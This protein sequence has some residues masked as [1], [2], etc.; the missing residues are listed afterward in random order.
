MTTITLASTDPA[1][2]KIDALVLGISPGR[3]KSVTIE[4]AAVP[5]KANA[6]RRLETALTALGATGRSGELVKVPGTGIVAAPVILAVGLGAPETAGAAV[7]DRLRR[8]AGEASRALIGTRR[9]GIALPIAEPGDATTIIEGALMGGYTFEAFRGVGTRERRLETRTFTVLVPDSKAAEWKQAAAAG[10]T[11]GNA[12]R[13]ARDLVNTPASHLAPENLAEAALVAADDLPLDVTVFDEND[14]LEGG[15]GGILSVGKGS[16]N[17]PRLIQLTYRHPSAKR[18]LALVGKGITFDSGGLSIKPAANMHLMKTDMAG[19]AAVLAAVVAIAELGLPLNVTG[20]LAA[21]ENM[22][23]G[24]AQ[25]PGDV[26]KHYDGHT[27]EVIDTDAEGRLVLADALARAAEDRPDLIVDVATLTGAAVVA[28][29]VRT[30]GVMG[31]DSAT[32]AQVVSAADRVA[33]PMWPMPMP[34]EIRATLDS[35]VADIA[36]LGDRKGGMLAGAIFL[37]EFIPAGIKWVHIDIAGPG[38]NTGSAFGYT[39]RGGTGFTVRTFV[40]LARELSAE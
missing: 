9:V 38:D 12:V 35:Q 8:A 22:P 7:T 11:V 18:H 10:E 27:V 4:T 19:A 28:L 26:I 32:R 23:S 3:G 17:P 25:R 37:R 1:T 16:S 13:R 31:N 29:G 39:P 34:V 5:L 20:W 6:L 14:L 40:E 24:A 15:F 30:A 33:E 36:N 2:L 21:A